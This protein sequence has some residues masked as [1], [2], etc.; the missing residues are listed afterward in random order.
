LTV[1]N[2]LNFNTSIGL[3]GLPLSS[4]LLDLDLTTFEKLS[5]LLT[6]K[7]QLMLYSYQKKI[8]IKITQRLQIII[9]RRFIKS[10]VP[11]FVEMSLS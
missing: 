4:I 3:E 11:I 2:S 1:D 8:L 6:N 5:N 10:S 7:C 9:I